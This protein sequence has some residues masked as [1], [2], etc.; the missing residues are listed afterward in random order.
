MFRFKHLHFNQLTFAWVLILFL[1]LRCGTTPINLGHK[2]NADTQ[3]SRVSRHKSIIGGPFTCRPK[4]TCSS[5]RVTVISPLERWNVWVYGQHLSTRTCINT[6]SSFKQ[7][8][9]VPQPMSTQCRVISFIGQT[10]PVR[11]YLSSLLLRGARELANAYNLFI[12]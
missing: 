5:L 7:E 3:S 2:S 6:S 12:N 8:V 4:I 1:S 10:L 11:L 9:S